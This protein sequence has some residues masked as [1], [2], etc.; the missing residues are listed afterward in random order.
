[1]GYSPWGRKELDMTE[2]LTQKMSSLV[3]YAF[4]SIVTFCCW[5]LYCILR[6]LYVCWIQVLYCI[7]DLLMFS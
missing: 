6:V 1:M 4:K 7:C 5:A 3:K 2:Q